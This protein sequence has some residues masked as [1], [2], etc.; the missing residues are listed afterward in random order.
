MG[1]HCFHL[2]H[3]PDEPTEATV[4]DDSRLNNNN[5]SKFTE[6]FPHYRHS[7]K[8]Q[9]LNRKSTHRLQKSYSA[10]SGLEPVSFRE[11]S[12][13]PWAG[14]SSPDS[15][16][17]SLSSLGWN[18]LTRK[19]WC[20]IL[21]Q[22]NETKMFRILWTSSQVLRTNRVSFRQLVCSL[23]IEEM[24]PTVLP[25]PETPSCPRN[26]RPSEMPPFLRTFSKRPLECAALG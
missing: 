10:H 6:C 15:W 9:Y 20:N 12:P 19:S 5:I 4:N 8:K 14:H 3:R 23:L 25:A 13:C 11:T 16:P 21:L 2:P 26:P 24:L 7:L 18:W 17:P 1:G 22:A